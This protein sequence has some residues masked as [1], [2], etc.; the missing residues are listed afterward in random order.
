MSAREGTGVSE[1][2]E[3]VLKE[4]DRADADL[5]IDYDTYAEGEALLGWLHGVSGAVY[6][7][8]TRL[9]RALPAGLLL[10]DLW[11]PLHVVFAGSRVW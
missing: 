1:W 9:F 4:A 8:R 3:A 6:A 2:F 7:L 11:I 10:D 5:P